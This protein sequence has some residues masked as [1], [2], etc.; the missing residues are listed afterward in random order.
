[1][2]INSR[3]RA[4]TATL[5]AVCLAAQL[6]MV[7]EAAGAEVFSRA[8]DARAKPPEYRKRPARY[9]VELRWVGPTLRAT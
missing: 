8:D 2:N 3:N 6:L 4:S 1:M 5:L 9:L 7:P